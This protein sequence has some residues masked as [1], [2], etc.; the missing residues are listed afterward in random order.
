MGALGVETWENLGLPRLRDDGDAG[1]PGP[2]LLLAGGPRRGDP[3]PRLARPGPPP[4]R[5]DALQRLRRVRPPRPHPGP[6]GGRRRLLPGGRSGVVPG[7]GCARAR[8]L[9]PGGGGRRPGAVGTGEALRAGDL[10]LASR[11]D[12]RP[13]GGGRDGVVVVAA[14][15][16]EP[17]GPGRLGRVHAP[18]DRR[19]R[20]DHDPDRRPRPRRPAL[21]G[22]AR[23]PDP[24]LAHGQPADGARDR[25]RSP[26]CGARRRSSCAPRASPWARTCPRRTSSPASAEPGGRTR[27]GRVRRR[28][29]RTIDPRYRPPRNDLEAAQPATAPLP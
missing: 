6:P 23:P 12:G 21:G 9:G 4:R 19:R 7:A 18:F 26:S 14:H 24:D 17:G 5:G 2:A 20:P 11:G 3:A 16:R 8:R 27:L 13:G 1:Q 28:S 25:R 15:R 29:C 22:A 10:P